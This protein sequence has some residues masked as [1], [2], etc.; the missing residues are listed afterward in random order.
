[1]DPRSG[2]IVDDMDGLTDEQRQHFVQFPEHLA[3]LAHEKLAGR[4]HAM[5]DISGNGKLASFAREQRNLPLTAA[6]REAHTEKPTGNAAQRR[7]RQMA[8]AHERA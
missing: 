8:K 5:V 4:R 2:M 7:L 6:E 1:M 3:K